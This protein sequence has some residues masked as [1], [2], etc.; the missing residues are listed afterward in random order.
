MTVTFGPT[1]A[2]QVD[3]DQVSLSVALHSRVFKQRREK[4]LV[5][6]GLANPLDVRAQRFARER[7]ARLQLQ[8]P[9]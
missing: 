8:R 7:R 6:E 5:D 9:A 2:V 4:S 1:A 3:R